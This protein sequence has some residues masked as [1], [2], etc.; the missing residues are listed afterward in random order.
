MIRLVL[1]S[2]QARDQARRQLAELTSSEVPFHLFLERVA[3][4]VVTTVGVDRRTRTIR[5]RRQGTRTFT[6]GD[7]AL[8]EVVLQDSQRFLVLRQRVPKAAVKAAIADS[9]SDGRIS[10]GW[11]RWR[12]DAQVCVALPLDTSLAQGRAVHIPPH[13]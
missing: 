11:D 9:R 7:L 12:G 2:P 4:I 6:R 5:G 10:A 1:R 3:S 13:G 8:D